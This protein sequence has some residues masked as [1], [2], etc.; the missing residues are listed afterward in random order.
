MNFYLKVILTLI[1]V[2]LIAYLGDEM[3]LKEKVSSLFKKEEQMAKEIKKVTKED[4]TP[5]KTARALEGSIKN[6]FHTYTTIQPWKQ[7]KIL[8][9]EKA[10][11]KKVHVYVGDEVKQGQL[12]VSLHSRLKKLKKELADLQFKIT[13]SDFL[14]TQNLARKNFVSKRELEQKKLQLRVTQLHRKIEALEN[15][16]TEIRSPIAGTIAEQNLKLGDYIS[17]PDKQS[18]LVVD[19]SKLLCEIYVPQSLAS[20]LDYETE[21]WLIRPTKVGEERALGTID[22]IS[23]ITDPKTGTIKIGIWI[24]QPPASWQPG[25]YAK[26]QITTVQ[27]D[28]IT[29]VLNH[30]FVV[31]EEMKSLF[32]V[33]EKLDG[34]SEVVQVFPSL[35]ISDE[36]YTEV[37]S[38]VYPEDQVVVKGQQTLRDNMKV[39][40]ITENE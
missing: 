2:A 6:Y 19:S 12:L 3:A 38:E 28:K 31:Q 11:V 13:N 24:D 40:V 15:D 10:R 17:K 37:K 18:I 7:V 30:A 27:K 22:T 16:K 20:S 21:V 32:L 23:P 5:V 34:S 1:G 25:M 9:M 33:Q 8:P 35:G 36:N 14:L 4:I 39:K 26:V 29:L